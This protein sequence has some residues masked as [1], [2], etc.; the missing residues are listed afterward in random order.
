MLVS[1]GK[2][3]AQLSNSTHDRRF[4][5]A[6]QLCLWFC[7]DLLSFN[8]VGKPGIHDFF[9]WAGVIK[10]DEKL[11][12]RTTL[13]NAALNDVYSSLSNHIHQFVKSKLPSAISISF[14]FWTDNVKR[15]SYMNFWIHWVDS[16]FAM[17]KMCL[18]FLRFPHPH[19]GESVAI[20]FE[21]L[22]QDYKLEDKKFL[23]VT[24][25]GKNL[26]KACRILKLDRD[27]CLAHNLHLLVATDLINKHPEMDCIRELISRMKAINKS[28]IYRYEELK[29][30]NDDEYNKRLFHVLST[31]K[32]ICEFAFSL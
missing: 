27:P 1:V 8:E 19:T 15:V 12:D 25:N 32:N 14:D 3:S 29:Q 20:A 5:L 23:A 16:E 22:K 4:L 11:P 2:E 18:G 28:L 21:N 24:D 31:L 6:R 13:A 26:K 17:R 9:V 7:R 30:I 10:K